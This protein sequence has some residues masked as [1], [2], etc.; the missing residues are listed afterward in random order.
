MYQVIVVRC[1]GDGA[2]LERLGAPESKRKGPES[3]WRDIPGRGVARLEQEQVG[4]R[5]G[6][7]T[8]CWGERGLGGVAGRGGPGVWGA[9]TCEGHGALQVPG[10]TRLSHATC[11]VQKRPQRFRPQ[12]QGPPAQGHGTS[13]RA[14]PCQEI[15]GSLLRP[16]DPGGRTPSL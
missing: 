5:P 2:Q 9:D 6:A 3:P 15:P 11:S 10:R 12:W 4:D 8:G 1:G 7:A 13:L 14:L 16:L